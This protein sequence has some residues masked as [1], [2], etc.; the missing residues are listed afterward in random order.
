MRFLRPKSSLAL[1]IALDKGIYRCTL[2]YMQAKR[3]LMDEKQFDA[4]KRLSQKTGAPVNELIRRAIDEYL[5]RQEKK[6]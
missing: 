2:E 5:K 1:K 6:A 3:L 4:L